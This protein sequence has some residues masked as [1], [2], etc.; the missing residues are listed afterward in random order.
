MKPTEEK[1]DAVKSCAPPQSKTEVRS[2]SGM[3]DYLSK[4]IPRNVS[5]TKHYEIFTLKDVKFHWGEE[6][7][8]VFAQLK[9]AITS[10]DVTAFFNPKLPI[11]VR[12]EAS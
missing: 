11:M 10:K 12:T 6:E 2:F 8:T 3:T 5:L 7:E 9:E 1:V 4:I